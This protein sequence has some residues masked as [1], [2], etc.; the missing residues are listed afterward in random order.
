MCLTWVPFSHEHLLSYTDTCLDPLSFYLLL[1]PPAL[2]APIPFSD[3]F[4]LVCSWTNTGVTFSFWYCQC[5]IP[6]C[7][8]L[9]LGFCTAGRCRFHHESLLLVPRI[10]GHGASNRC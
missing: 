8:R 4:F 10:G 6:R 2:P 3:P 5:Q 1:F 9:S 7:D